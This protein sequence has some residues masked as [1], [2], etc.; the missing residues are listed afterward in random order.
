MCDEYVTLYCMRNKQIISINGPILPFPRKAMYISF[1]G[2]PTVLHHDTRLAYLSVECSQSGQV[3][4]HYH[5]QPQ[6]QLLHQ[7]LH[8]PH[9]RR[10]QFW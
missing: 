1:P 8:N 4:V 3:S 2:I 9:P 6:Q 10:H 7:C 5:H